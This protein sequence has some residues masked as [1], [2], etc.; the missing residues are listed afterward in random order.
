M[1]KHSC[2]SLFS[3]FNEQVSE[4]ECVSWDVFDTL[5]RRKIAPPEQVQVPS[6]V[7]LA[8]LLKLHKVEPN[9][10]GVLL[11]TRRMVERQLWEDALS[12]GKD[13]EAKIR[14]IVREWLQCYLPPEAAQL[15]IEALVLA[16]LKAELAVCHADKEALE[17]VKVAKAMGKRN[18]FISDMH[19]GSKEI[20]TILEHTGYSSLFDKGYTSSDIGLRK[21]G[22]RLFEH[23]LREEKLRP[24]ELLHIGDNFEADYIAPRSLGIKAIHF[25]DSEYWRWNARHRKLV[26]LCRA[27]PRWEGARWAEM[28]PPGSIQVQRSREDPAYAVGCRVL[29]PVLVNFIHRASVRMAEDRVE[30]ALFPSREGFLL[31]EIF[32]RLAPRLSLIREPE[33]RYIFLSR[34]S[35][36]LP[37]IHRIGRREIIKGLENKPTLS[38]FL[39]KLGMSAEPLIEPARACGFRSLDEPVRDPFSDGRFAAFIKHPVF[40]DAL[41]ADSCKA[42]TVLYNY[43]KAFGFWEVSRV[44][45][46]DVGWEG[47]IQESLALAFMDRPE[48]PTM[49]GYY[50]ALLGSGPYVCRESERCEFNGVLFDYRKDRD[51]T[52][53]G[54]FT[55]LFETAARAP[56]GTTLGYRE[57]EGRPPVPI[58]SDGNSATGR[59]ES[60]DASLV[61]SLQAGV[62]DYADA[63]SELVPFQVHPPEHH[64]PFFLDQVD[65]LVR[66]PLSW[67]IELLMKIVL[68]DEFKGTGYVPEKRA[69]GSLGRAEPA[70]TD[71]G[72]T[73]M[74]VW[75][76]GR[77]FSVPGLGFV[78][79]LYRA[80]FKR[81]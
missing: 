10:L 50:M 5:L 61:A 37:S 51:R 21:T 43:L 36:Y 42:R 7:A 39:G 16:E 59:W 65:R 78:Y 53:I 8:H 28:L 64:T 17:A 44:A 24:S 56:H 75:P 4:T 29:G 55:E 26:R 81:F 22:G 79:N 74:N 46:L 63:Y 13:P 60:M 1:V 57:C 19:F 23:V 58:L 35:T 32:H 66:F 6:G 25:E 15:H 70:I 76:E 3:Y 49:K 72:L 80:L 62:L 71:R 41:S 48:L 11:N 52:G 34:K 38:G 54:R 31:K 47:S 68:I 40:L 27:N 69:E 20:L 2:K 14:D 18:I 12:S 67:E 77:F 9:P 33:A 73:G 45:I 30:L